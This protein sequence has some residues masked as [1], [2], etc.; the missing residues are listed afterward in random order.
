MVRFV[1]GVFLHSLLHGL[2]KKF[3]VYVDGVFCLSMVQDLFA[4]S[5]GSLIFAP[6]YD[7]ICT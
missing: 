6:Q 1:K 7:T 5:H 2:L 3:C 4:G